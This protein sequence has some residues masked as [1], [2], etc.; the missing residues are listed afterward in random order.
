MGLAQSGR[1]LGLGPRGCRFK[2][3]V[4][5]HFITNKRKHMRDLVLG[6]FALTALIA[7]V[8]GSYYIAKNVSYSMFYEDLVLETI[9]EKVQKKCLNE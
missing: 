9:S 7:V 6:V 1:A 4:P 2:S 8:Y 5:H 3:Y